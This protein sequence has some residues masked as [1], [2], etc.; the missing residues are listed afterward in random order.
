MFLCPLLDDTKTTQKQNMNQQTKTPISLSMNRHEWMMIIALSVLWGGSFFFYKILLEAGLPVFLIVLTR[1]GLAMII[2][3]LWLVG[4]RDFM[5]ATP[6]LWLEFGI[7]GFL[8]NLLPFSLIVFGEQRIS[9]GM[10]SI[11]NATTPI[12]TMVIA[13]F[14]TTTEKL[15]IYKIIGILFGM[16]GV[17][18]LVGPTALS[19]THNSAMAGIFCCLAASVS[20]SF[21]SI[22]SKRF[23]G[24]NPIKVVTGQITASTFLLL[25]IVLI[26]EH[27]LT[28]AMPAPPI[29]AAML[30]LS[31]LSTIFAYILFFRILATAGATNAQLV[32]FLIPISALLLSWGILDE[33]IKLQSILGMVIIGLGLASIDGRIFKFFS[34]RKHFL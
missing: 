26:F 20:Y 2:L 28:L 8:N 4:Q 23:R 25:P 7:M 29:W 6:R 12:F 13:H 14:L 10:A 24:M 27:P 33:T 11:L 16:I 3:N 32:T 18:V 22:Y 31:L 30:G 34:K 1:V 9:S 17:A 5:P 19:G 21:A 15:S